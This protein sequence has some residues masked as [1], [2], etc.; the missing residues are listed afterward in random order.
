MNLIIFHI[1]YINLMNRTIFKI[2][3]ICTY[4]F[5]IVIIEKI[6][7]CNNQNVTANA[8]IALKIR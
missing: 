1:D 4:L 3:Y 7:T 6:E 2:R 5:Y 8:Q